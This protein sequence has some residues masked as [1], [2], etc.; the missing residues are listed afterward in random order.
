[1]ELKTLIMDEVEAL[2]YILWGVEVVP[3]RY[4][5]LV[6]VYID[7]ADTKHQVSVDDCARVN[8]R[9]NLCLRDDD[10]IFEISS[11]GLARKF[12]NPGQYTG[13]IGRHIRVRTKMP[14][15]GKRNFTGCLVASDEQT[16]VLAE[17]DVQGEGT[18]THTLVH[19]HI[20]RG[21]LEPDYTML[22]KK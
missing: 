11:P 3:S 2:G 18:K 7:G 4:S 5:C 22:F 16:L 9:L 6:R 8:R 20:E 13:Y 17:H 15:E 1:M 19:S 10:C 14:I 12:F 21:Q